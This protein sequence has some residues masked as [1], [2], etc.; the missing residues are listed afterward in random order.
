MIF[1]DIRIILESSRLPGQFH[2][3]PADQLIVSTARVMDIPLCTQDGKILSYP[4][5]KLI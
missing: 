5:V 1:L 4:H 3:D 2:K